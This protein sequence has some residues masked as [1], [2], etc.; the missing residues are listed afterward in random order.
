MVKKKIVIIGGGYAGLACLRKLCTR[1]PSGKAEIQLIDSS[2]SHA[3][4]SRFHERAA[5]PMREAG[6]AF[7]LSLLV[8]SAGGQFLNDEVLSVDFQQNMVAG[9][10]GEFSYN[11]L[12]LAAGGRANYFGIE[13]AEKNAIPIDTLDSVRRCAKAFKELLELKKGKKRAIVC[14]AGIE[15]VEVITQLRQAAGGEAVEF[16][17]VDAGEKVLPATTNTLER[18][19]TLAHLEYKGIKLLM[20]QRINSIDPGCVKLESGEEIDAE[21]IIWCGGISPPKIRGLEGR[22]PLEVDEFL[23]STKYSE[24]FAAGD[25]AALSNPDNFANLYSA[26]RAVYQGGLC[27]S[28]IARHIAGKPLEKAS[29]RPVGELVALGDFDGAGEIFG[30][31]LSGVVAAALKKGNE[32]KYLVELFSHVPPRVARGLLTPALGLVKRGGARNNN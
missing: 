28:N 2:P 18:N 14:G 3:I 23:R 12:V 17:L 8:S 21:L 16:T 32:A 29:Y 27:G 9:R 22:K 24:V 7:S 6:V 30:F 5:S 15:G 11:I 13:G 4:K 20:G 19:A 10:Q 31:S 26:Q 1:I 25:C